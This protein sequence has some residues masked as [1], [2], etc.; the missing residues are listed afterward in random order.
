LCE[1]S[2]S[3]CDELFRALSEVEEKCNRETEERVMAKVKIYSKDYCPYCVKVKNFFVE[4][5]KVEVEE[6]DVTQDPDTLIKIVEQT[7]MRTVPQVFIGDH[8]C[9]GHD[10][11][12]SLESEGKIDEL[13]AS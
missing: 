7:N 4:V 13:L 8:F 6:I 10:D 2:S 11:V 5:K 9:G 12:M 1:L 3:T